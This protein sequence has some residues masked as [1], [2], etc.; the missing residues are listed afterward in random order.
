[1]LKEQFPLQQIPN[2]KK[3]VP[4]KTK[5]IKIHITPSGIDLDRQHCKGKNCSYSTKY[6]PL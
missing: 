2:W 6:K 5:V 4:L 3:G 1:M